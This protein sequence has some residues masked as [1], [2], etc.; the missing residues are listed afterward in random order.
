M[1]LGPLIP[2]GVAGGVALA[3]LA[4]GLLALLAFA[5]CAGLL[6]A[7]KH[8]LGALIDALTSLLSVHAFGVRINFGWPLDKLNN[9]VQHA[10]SLGVRESEKAMGRFFHAAGVV[11]GWMVN[12]MLATATTMQH[13]FAWLVHQGIPKLAKNLVYVA[14][15]PALLYRLIAHAVARMLPRTTKIAHAAAHDATTV[16]YK[17]V[18]SEAARLTHDETL[19]HRLAARVEHLAGSIALPLPIDT[20][21]VNWRGFT[22]R[23]ARINRRLHRVESLLGATAMALAMA[24]VLGVSARC[25][26]SGNVGKVARRLCGM[27][28]R[29][30]N[31]LLG[32]LADLLIVAN[33][34][35]AITYLED[36]LSLVQPEITAFIGGIE[37]WAC[38]GD[39]EH[40]P[41]LA[42]TALSLPPTTGVTLSLP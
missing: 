7:W 6:Y 20:P 1:A 42:A 31:D 35:Q 26:R 37:A 3:D 21:A 25:L 16:V 23:L 29:A 13:A 17:P 33:I 19:L 34:C 28:P 38:Y 10:L 9:Y 30:I 41:A 27:S 5:V 24:N 40:P 22:R 14:Y 11:V 39:R 2:E 12:Y 8:S 15:P 18:R 36:G 4:L 32:L